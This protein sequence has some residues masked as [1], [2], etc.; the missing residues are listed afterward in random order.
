MPEVVEVAIM[1]RSMSPLIGYTLDRILI[2]RKSKFHSSNKPISNI[3]DCVKKKLIDVR[4]YAKKI[5]FELEDQIYLVN[6]PLMEGHWLWEKHNHSNFEMIFVDQDSNE[7]VIYYDD[8]RKFG[9]FTVIKGKD[10]LDEFIK[11]KVGPD[12][13][14]EDISY[15][16][17]IAT[18]RKYQ[19]WQ[20]CKFLMDQTKFS[21]IGNYL[22]S[23]ILYEAKIMP[24]RKIESLTD[25]ELMNI[26][27]CT[28]KIIQESYDADG[29]TIATFVDS[30]GKTG[31]YKP[32]VYGLTYDT[33]G[34]QIVKEKFSDG[35]MSHYVIEIQ[36]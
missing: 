30:E 7:K 25:I 22:K 19:N 11:S 2:N 13:M 10:K 3:K 18:S 14:R 32:R 17:W 16:Q 34:Y 1:A 31:K 28:K 26:L 21:G 9:L 4:S 33:N 29:F 5:I 12:L 6:S 15:L 24:D 8:K 20:I 23:E 27:D 36:K 35:R